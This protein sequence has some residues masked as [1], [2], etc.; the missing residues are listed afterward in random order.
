M[1]QPGELPPNEN[2]LVTI[3]LITCG[4]IGYE[5]RQNKQQEEPLIISQKTADKILQ[6]LLAQCMGTLDASFDEVIKLS[7]EASTAFML[8]DMLKNTVP[9]TLFNQFTGSVLKHDPA[10][11][12]VP[13]LFKDFLNQILPDN[14][15]GEDQ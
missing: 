12:E 4:I 11:N 2:K 15:N 13:K 9:D 14:E 1:K 7:G 3:M 8:L 5:M 6:L 10:D